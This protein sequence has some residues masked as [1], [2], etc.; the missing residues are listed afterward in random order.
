MVPAGAV[1]RR[2]PTSRMNV[3]K[4]R[5]KNLSVKGPHQKTVGG[6]PGIE[7]PGGVPPT[8]L[9]QLDVWA[10]EEMG[11]RVIGG[12]AVGACGVVGPA[13]RVTVSLEP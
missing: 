6:L 7:L 2:G 4:G 5:D 12:M 8:E 10:A 3:R 9:G 13:Y 1:M 11:H